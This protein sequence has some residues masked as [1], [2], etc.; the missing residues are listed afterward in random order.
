MQVVKAGAAYESTDYESHFVVRLVKSPQS[1]QECRLSV[2]NERAGARED[3]NMGRS[4]AEAR[5]ADA[6]TLKRHRMVLGACV[7]CGKREAA[8]LAAKA[9][10]DR[11]LPSAKPLPAPLHAVLPSSTKPQVARPLP[12]TAGMKRCPHCAEDI[13]AEAVA[14]RSCGRDL[15]CGDE[16][17]GRMQHDFQFGKCIHCG[18]AEAWVAKYENLC[19]LDLSKPQKVVP[20]QVA[21]GITCPKCSS[22]SITDHKRGFGVGKAL[23][24]GVLTGGVGL[25]AGFIGSNA[26]MV[27]CLRCGHNWQAGKRR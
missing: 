5:R 25:L 8:I 15:D 6:E 21:T 14:C 24:G 22:T 27:T 1:S 4:T 16:S 3:S 13:K 20:R 2:T 18:Y 23:V 17:E 26:V 19:I 9:P 11:V 12:T 7:D 10:C